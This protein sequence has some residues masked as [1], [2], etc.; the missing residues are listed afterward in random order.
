MRGTQRC[1]RLEHGLV[2]AQRQEDLLARIIGEHLPAQP[3]H[4]FAQQDE[5]DVAIDEARAGRPGGL[6]D[7]S[8][9]RMPVS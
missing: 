8:A 4:Q 3:V 5:I 9:R 7:A 2:H 6:V 1:R